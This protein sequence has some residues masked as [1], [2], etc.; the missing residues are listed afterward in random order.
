MNIA[1][2]SLGLVILIVT[3]AQWSRALTAEH[4][5]LDVVQ[6]LALPVAWGITGYGLVR[7][8]EWGRQL[9]LLNCAATVLYAIITIAI[10]RFVS[11]ET[12][13]MLVF[14][15]NVA[16]LLMR[17]SA[18]SAIAHASQGSDREPQ[19]E[20]SLA[21][22]AALI[23]FGAIWFAVLLPIT[24]GLWNWYWSLSIVAKVVL[25]VLAGSYFAGFAWITIAVPFS[26][27]SYFFD[28]AVREVGDAA[29]LVAASTDEVSL[30]SRDAPGSPRSRSVEILPTLKAKY[31]HYI[32]ADITSVRFSQDGKRCYLEVHTVETVGGYLQNEAM[33]RDDLGFI[34]DGNGPFF[35]PS[36]PITEN[37]RRFVEEFDEI[38]IVNCTDLFRP[39]VAAVIGDR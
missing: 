15:V 27:A 36:R 14:G 8:R 1:I 29:P 28:V 39:D 10:N 38:S 33:K 37:V 12:L 23:L 24:G 20:G 25:F 16:F 11:G 31:P 18:V 2:R 26:V 7:L 9:M 17:R 6:N 34:S 19:I 22:V 13:G 21:G 30:H 32:R 5:E 4:G 35:D 3:L